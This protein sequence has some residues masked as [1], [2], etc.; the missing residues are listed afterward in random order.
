ML[1]GS[2]AVHKRNPKSEEEEEGRIIQ[3]GHF[4]DKMGKVL[5][6]RASALFGAKTSDFLKFMVCPHGQE[7]EGVEPMQTFFG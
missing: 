5:Q 2:G 4:S 7:E 6:M 1:Y 3:C